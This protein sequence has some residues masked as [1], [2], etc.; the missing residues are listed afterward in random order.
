M[1][2]TPIIV[3]AYKVPKFE[4]ELKTAGYTY[5]V[6]DFNH[7]PDGRM[8]IINLGAKSD[9]DLAQVV[10]R[11]SEFFNEGMVKIAADVVIKDT[12]APNYEA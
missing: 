10:Q 6:K 11:V 1:N 4:E 3:P 2:K 5:E 7:L 12:D 8:I 9:E